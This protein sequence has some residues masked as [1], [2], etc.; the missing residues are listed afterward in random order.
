MVGKVVK[1]RIFVFFTSELETQFGRL[2]ARDTGEIH[3]FHP[4][5]GIW[6]FSTIRS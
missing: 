4:E 1:T 5:I 2:L 3:H 6:F